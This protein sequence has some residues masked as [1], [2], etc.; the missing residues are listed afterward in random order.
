MPHTVSIILVI[1]YSGSI[2]YLEAV[3]IT[4]M[5]WGQQEKLHLEAI[6]IA[7]AAGSYVY[8]SFRHPG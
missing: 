4:S 3:E 7:V 2:Y 1:Y 6:G 5:P 8:Y